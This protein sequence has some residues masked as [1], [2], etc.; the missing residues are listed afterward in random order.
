MHQLALLMLLLGLVSGQA[1]SL[2]Y[3]QRL[4]CNLTL[5]HLRPRTIGGSYLDSVKPLVTGTCWAVESK[6]Q[7]FLITA[8]HNLGL[9]PNFIPATPPKAKL[10]AIH[11]EPIVGSLA[12]PL[13]AVGMPAV[14]SDWVG[15]RP[16]DASVFK[17]SQVL[18]LS[19]TVSKLGDSV[20]VIGFPDT[21]HEQRTTRT[22][23]AV[24]PSN[25]FVVFSQ[26]LEPGYSGGV[27]LNAKNQAVGVVV[28]TDKKQ[29]TALLL[30]PDKITS[31]QWKPFEQV[32]HRR[33]EP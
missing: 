17:S 23:T 1:Q 11:V 22:I 2:P 8:A 28:T 10:L 18:T 29:S 25:D 14:N 24:S 32:R 9:G 30:S 4:Y 26:P 21:S 19:K 5:E 16:I 33:V 15:L 7:T 31:L 3:T 27:V 6:G 13:S 12:Q 20:T